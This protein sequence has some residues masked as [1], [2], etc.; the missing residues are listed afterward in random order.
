MVYKYKKFPK[1]K[2]K[3]LTLQKIID[4][5][6]KMQKK[7]GKRCLPFLIKP[8]IYTENINLKDGVFFGHE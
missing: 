7:T 5:M 8:G 6:V 1:R 3:K 2:R 4:I